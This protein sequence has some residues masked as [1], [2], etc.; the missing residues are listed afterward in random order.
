MKAD[1]YNVKGAKTGT[2]E[3][4]ERVFGRKWSAQL[5]HQVLVGQIKNSRQVLAH[6]KGRDE[7]RGGGKKPWA[8]KHTGRAR[9]SSI[10]S[11]LWKGGGV[12]HGPSK[13]VNFSVK[14]N[15]RMKQAAIFAVL[16]RK[17]KD[18]EIKIVE[19]LGIEAPKTKNVA[20]LLKALGGATKVVVGSHLLI[21]DLT[22]KNIF[23]ASR[24]IP[25]TK[26][27]SP[28]A[29]NVYDLMRYKSILLDRSAVAAIDSTYTDGVEKKTVK[30]TAK[31]K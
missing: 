16:S 18:G 1:L 17:L 11:P 29:L 28:K 21:P 14:V 26:S 10:R 27:L 6:A 23:K 20:E 5:V 19:S 2:V 15:K 3:L 8:Q 9:H 31:S 7:V 13:D 30:E 22:N 24:N 12:A 4:P 25:K